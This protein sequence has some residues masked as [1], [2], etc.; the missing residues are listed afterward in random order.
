MGRMLEAL[1]NTAVPRP[2]SPEPAIKVL[3]PE[4]DTVDLS[5]L[6]D[7]EAAVSFIE[8]GGPRH[9]IDASPD[10]LACKPP[11]RAVVAAPA[12]ESAPLTGTW[13][14]RF[15]SLL[16]TTIAARPV[17]RRIAAELIAYH[18]PEQPA[19]EAY[20]ALLANLLSQLPS[21]R[22]QALLFTAAA[23]WVGT[24]TVLLNLAITAAKQGNRRVLLVDGNARRPAV[25]ERLDLPST[26]GFREVLSTATSLQA[27]LQETSQPG[28]YALAAGT[29]TGPLAGEAAVALLGQ[30]C[31]QFDLVFVD[32]ASWNEGS[33]T[34]ALAAG[35]DA[36]YLVQRS[37]D[38]RQAPMPN[39]VSLLRQPP[40]NLR[41]CIMTMR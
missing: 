37:M 1:K 40:G 29:S 2:S 18:Q 11:A 10:V 36:V 19:S 14:V 27:A 17:A 32:A 9:A 22:G 16:A 31:E 34:S 23:P 25:A 20:R 28:L 12:P 33:E 35:C 38:E 3:V 24:T 6:D 4:A 15:Q 8:V 5:I 21:A 39:P 30:L 41:G 7:D 13:P 26:S